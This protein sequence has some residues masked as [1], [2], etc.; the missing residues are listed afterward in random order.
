M[1]LEIKTPALGWDFVSR[2]VPVKALDL[3]AIAEHAAA[4]GR[5][6]E[7]GQT[8]PAAAIAPAAAPVAA[9]QAVP[10]SDPALDP[11]LAGAVITLTGALALH[12]ARSN[13]RGRRWPTF[14]PGR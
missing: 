9:E 11:V 3:I 6:A 2:E 12:T 7:P 5:I 8:G 13:S 1:P 4:L 10:E 14:W